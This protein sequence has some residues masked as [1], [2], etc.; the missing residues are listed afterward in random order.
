MMSQ[1]F[2]NDLWGPSDGGD[3]GLGSGISISDVAAQS[4]Q[5]TVSGGNMSPPTASDIPFNDGWGVVDYG[6]KTLGSLAAIN[7]QVKGL[8]LSQYLQRGQ[9]DIARTNITAASEIARTNA[10]TAEQV[11][12]IKAN[13]ATSGANL[14]ALGQNQNSFMLILTIIGVAF[15]GLQLAKMK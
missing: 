5:E 2:V 6:L 14:A 12:K 10:T 3:L 7:S 15:A 8:E 9:M 11:A 13:A 4:Q 1:S